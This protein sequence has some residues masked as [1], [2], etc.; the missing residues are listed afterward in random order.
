MNQTF[1]RVLVVIAVSAL[2]VAGAA[3]AGGDGGSDQG[4]TP[5]GSRSSASETV[6]PIPEG[7]SLM[8]PGIYLAQTEPNI[9]LTTISP[10]YGAANSPGFVDFG[11]LDHFPYAELLLLN[12]DEV[13][14]NPSD[15][16]DPLRLRPAPEDLLEWLV[17]QAG[18]EIVGEAVPVEIDGLPGQQADI[19]VRSDADCAPKHTRPFPQA[20]LLFFSTSGEPPGFA[21][22]RWMAYR[23]TV[24]PDVGGRA[25]TLLYTD[26]AGPRFDERAAVAD[27]VVRSI[28]F[29]V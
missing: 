4:G 19:R 16:G 3:C 11:Q 5:S 9:T 27:E 8:D 29:D 17:D 12:L 24:L 10:W 1:V 15:P 13:V 20:C 21:F 2:A 7:Q 14:Q 28:E 26:L 18:M 6:T 22:A 23:I 25:V